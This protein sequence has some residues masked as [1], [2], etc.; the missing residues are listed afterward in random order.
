MRDSKGMLKL[1]GKIALFLAILAGIL[2]ILSEVI[3]RA[4]INDD[5]IVH[6]VNK[7][8]YN[9][10][11]QPENTMDVV[12]TGD[13]VTYFAYN[14]IVI[15]EEQGIA[16]Y[17]CGQPAQKIQESYIM[18]KNVYKTQKPKLVLLE[19]DNFFT[20]NEE[21]KIA[22]I[23]DTA[24]EWL[25]D[26]FPLLR[27]HD[28]W[29]SLF[30]DKSYHEDCFKGY[31]YRDGVTPVDNEEY[32]IDNGQTRPVLPIARDYCKKIKELCDENG[33][34]LLFVSAPSKMDYNFEMHNG[35]AELAKE[36]GVDYLDMNLVWQEIGIDWQTDTFDNG[37]HLNVSGAEKTSK[38]LG[39]YLKDNY[40]L[41]D[42]RGEAAFASFD[43]EAEAYRK[44]IAVT[45]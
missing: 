38:Y 4:C 1:I 43:A 12:V 25:K 8:V 2:L 9:V 39:K 35:A 5:K 18:L 24:K 3:H 34:T 30:T 28:V 31:L 23:K 37:D 6:D 29:K 7:S 11:R 41:P 44:C 14:P 13:S 42:R 27:G 26:A 10:A 33:S 22:N 19:T 45:K 16:S 15:W 17:I 21:G 36:L 32:M 40:D 20:W